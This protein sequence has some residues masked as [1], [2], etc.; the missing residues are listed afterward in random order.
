MSGYS[1]MSAAEYPLDSCKVSGQFGRVYKGLWMCEGEA[2]HVAVKDLQEDAKEEDRV[3]FLQEAA[4]MGQFSHFNIIR[5]YGVVTVGAPVSVCLCVSVC[6]CVLVSVCV[7][8]SEWKYTHYVL[9]M[10]L[11]FVLV[12]V[13]DCSGA[14]S[15]RPPPIP[16]WNQIQVKPYE[17]THLHSM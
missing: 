10:A 16:P 7:C 1:Q 17:S 13:S 2:L 6:V 14:G 5:L 8:W 3:K 11:V 9:F 12:T 15:H 4:L